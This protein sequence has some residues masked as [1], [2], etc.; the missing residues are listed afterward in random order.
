MVKT[1]LYR[2]NELMSIVRSPKIPIQNLSTSVHRGSN[3]PIEVS[4]LGILL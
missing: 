1:L 4:T 3:V 2:K